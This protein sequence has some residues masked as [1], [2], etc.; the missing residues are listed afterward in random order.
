[1][2]SI[3]NNQQN[4]QE[5]DELKFE[6]DSQTILTPPEKEG[7]EYLQ[8]IYKF[9]GQD[10][11]YQDKY[12]CLKQQVNIKEKDDIDR[13]QK[14]ECNCEICIKENNKDSDSGSQFRKQLFKHDPEFLN[15]LEQ[16][17]YYK[18]YQ[19]KQPNQNKLNLQKLNRAQQRE[20]CLNDYDLNYLMQRLQPP[21]KQIQSLRIKVPET[22]FFSKWEIVLAVY[23]MKNGHLRFIR[24]RDKLV[25]QELRKFMTEKRSQYKINVIQNIEANINNPE[26]PDEC[27]KQDIQFLESLQKDKQ[28]NFKNNKEK[29]QFQI[30]ENNKAEAVFI[31][32]FREKEFIN[33]QNPKDIKQKFINTKTILYEQEFINLMNKRKIDSVWQNVL[34]IQNYIPVKKNKYDPF[35][36]QFDLIYDQDEYLFKRSQTIISI[37]N[38]GI[39]SGSKNYISHDFEID[40]E[41]KLLMI[42]PFEYA[43]YLTYKMINYVK[44]FYQSQ[45]LKMQV[46]WIIDDNQEVYL[47]DVQNLEKSDEIFQNNDELDYKTI[48]QKLTQ[49]AESILNIPDKKEEQFR[50]IERQEIE[51]LFSDLIKEK[52]IQKIKERLEMRNQKKTDENREIE[53]KLQSILNH[54]QPIQELEKYVLGAQ[55]NK[56]K[57]KKFKYNPDLL[58]SKHPNSSEYNFYQKNVTYQSQLDFQNKKDSAQ[59][60]DLNFRAPCYRNLYSLPFKI[61]LF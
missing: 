48:T 38:G 5:Q 6:F 7:Y 50:K 47:Q 20:K 2:E 21:N 24:Q 44:C 34:Y 41:E 39:S 29:L 12:V 17:D 8:R 31:K 36:I 26:I 51:R 9:K 61:Y 45:I 32:T 59:I 42:N 60:F 4:I 30:E 11:Q 53:Q 18:G 46:Y 28:Q 49:Q 35:K 37:M 27:K 14:I 33:E 19:K 1:M 40:F 10:T 15:L 43:K 57:K 52:E 22:I 16:S 56:T 54:N 13:L 25:F 58:K 23:T 55:E 3:K